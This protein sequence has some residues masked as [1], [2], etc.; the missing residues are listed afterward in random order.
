MPRSISSASWAGS[1][2]AVGL[3]AHLPELAVA[4]GLHPLVAK[5]RPEVVPA[6]DRL[7]LWP[8]RARRRRA[9][10]RG[11]L[12]AQGQASARL[13]LEGVHLLPDD[14]GRLAHAADEERGVLDQ[15]RA[16]LLVA[17]AAE[18]LARARLQ[19]VPDRDVR[20]KEVVHPLHAR[21]SL[22]HGAPPIRWPMRHRP[23]PAPARVPDHPARLEEEDDRGAHLEAAQLL[24]LAPPGLARQVRP[25]PRGLSG[26]GQ[27]V[28]VGRADTSDAGGAHHHHRAAADRACRATSPA[29]R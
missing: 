11:A 13:V 8:P 4:A 15:R 22:A 21:R 20:R 17:E 1:A 10:R 9:P 24:A 18:R 5:H 27:H 26:V 12:R 28:V 19:E 2:D 23:R 14:V 3:G 29:A 25:E 7:A 16:D 6:G